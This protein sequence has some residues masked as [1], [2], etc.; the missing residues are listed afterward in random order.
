MGEETNIWR[1]R[2][3]S[4]TLSQRGSIKENE[5]LR[6][7]QLFSDYNDIVDT[8]PNK[9]F[10]TKENK[11]LP[12]IKN[13]NKPSGN[14]SNTLK[15]FN[16]VKLPTTNG[17]L[18]N[19]QTVVDSNKSPVYTPQKAIDLFTNFLTDFEKKEILLFSEIYY[20]GEKKDLKKSPDTNTYTDNSG[21]YKHTPHDHLAYR[22]EVI[23]FLGKG[24]FGQV[25]KTHDYKL[26]K[27]TAVKMIKKGQKYYKQVC[28]GFIN[29]Y[30]SI[31]IKILA[32][33]FYILFISS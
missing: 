10:V 7:Q 32:K 14:S 4:A 30:T 8:S 5:G 16:T 21:M 17:H 12:S 22:Y 3:A 18:V 9:A 23:S 25:L 15:S 26:K 24:S 20:V 31:V 28:A 33:T 19:R 11:R 1:Q 27:D 6:V 29:F 13:N 2:R